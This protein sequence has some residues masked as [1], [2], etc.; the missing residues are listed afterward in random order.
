MSIIVL[1]SGWL[2][3]AMVIHALM[4]ISGGIVSFRVLGARAVRPA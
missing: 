2:I 1:A 4:D 3:P